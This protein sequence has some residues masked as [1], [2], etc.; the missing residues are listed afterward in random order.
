MTPARLRALVAHCGPP[1]RGA[2]GPWSAATALRRCLARAC[3]AGPSRRSR[4]RAAPGGPSVWTQPESRAQLRA[5]RALTSGS[6]CDDGYPIDDELPGSAGGP[7]RRGRATRRARRAAGRDRR[8]RAPRRRTGSPT[9]ASSAPYLAESGI[10]VVSGLAI[11]IDGAAH[12]GRARGRRDGRRCRRDR[13]RRRVPAPSP[14]ALPS[15]SAG[16]GSC[17]ARPASG[18][19]P[20]PRRF[21]VRNRIIA[22]LADVVVVVEATLARGCPDHRGARD[23]QYGRPVFAV[24]GSRRNPSAEG[25][26]ALHRRRRVSTRRLVRRRGRA[27]AHPGFATARSRRGRPRRPT[28][29]CSYTPW[30]ANRHR[31]ISSRSARTCRSSASRSRSPTSSA[32]DGSNAH[33]AGCGLD[34]RATGRA[35]CR[36]SR[37]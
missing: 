15:A 23:A 20:S 4:G 17:W 24:P 26:N 22:A 3:P 5:P 32:P 33:G 27:R 1:R 8:A 2:R 9:R 29:A 25:T 35:E 28:V 7:P 6:T 30:P 18:S 34:D 12:E 21:P 36:L 19:G 13:T 14:R 16:P 37:R 10:T 31:R 11:G